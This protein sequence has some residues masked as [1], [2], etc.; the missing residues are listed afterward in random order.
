MRS[1]AVGG[2]PEGA[3]RRH[4]RSLKKLAAFAGVAFSVDAIKNWAVAAIDAAD[5]VS[6]QMAKTGFSARSAIALRPRAARRPSGL[7]GGLSTLQTN[8]QAITDYTDATSGAL[9][10][11]GLTAAQLKGQPPT[12]QLETSRNQ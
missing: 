11:L 10:A 1:S 3:F 2:F 4:I 12:T 9:K 8:L 5:Q 7:I 6:A